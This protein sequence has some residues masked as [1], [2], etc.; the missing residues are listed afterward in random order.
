MRE[1]R[2]YLVVIEP[3]L[4]KTKEGLCTVVAIEYEADSTLDTRIKEY[5]PGHDFDQ[6]SQFLYNLKRK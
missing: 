4:R 1:I 6:I 3:C 5:W 2:M